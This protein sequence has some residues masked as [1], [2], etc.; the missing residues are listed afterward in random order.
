MKVNNFPYGLTN[1]ILIIIYVRY[2]SLAPDRNH[3]MFIRTLI[4][5]ADLLF[6]NFVC[7]GPRPFKLNLILPQHHSTTAPKRHIAQ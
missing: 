6:R 3:I 1:Y 4:P 2:L 7:P 5:K